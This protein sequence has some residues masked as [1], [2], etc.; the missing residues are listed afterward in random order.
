MIPAAPDAARV[1]RIWIERVE[2]PMPRKVRAAAGT[3]P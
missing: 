3:L 1:R 2:S